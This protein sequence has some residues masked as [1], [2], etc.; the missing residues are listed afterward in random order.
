MAAAAD[1]GDRVLLK[2]RSAR[3]DK[4]MRMRRGD[5]FSKLFAAYR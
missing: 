3:G 5:P 1:E 2:L 4:E